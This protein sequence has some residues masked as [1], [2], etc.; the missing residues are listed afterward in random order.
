MSGNL[1]MVCSSSVRLL[2]FLL[3]LMISSINFFFS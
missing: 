2:L 3:R 1:K